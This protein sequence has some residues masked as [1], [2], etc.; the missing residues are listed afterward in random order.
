MCVSPANYNKIIEK[1]KVRL[2][3]S[4]FQNNSIFKAKPVKAQQNQLQPVLEIT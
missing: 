4:L 2:S 1:H 3:L